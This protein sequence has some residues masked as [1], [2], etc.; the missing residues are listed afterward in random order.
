M[1]QCVSSLG[2]LLRK[3]VHRFRQRTCYY[4]LLWRT[5][6]LSI[7]ITVATTQMSLLKQQWHE[8]SKQKKRELYWKEKTSHSRKGANLGNDARSG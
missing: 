6:S 5:L 2:C 3:G 7:S 1:E 8:E 4:A